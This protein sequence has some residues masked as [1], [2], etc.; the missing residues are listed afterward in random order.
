M[1]RPI[2]KARDRPNIVVVMTDQHAARAIGVVGDPA[3]DTPA[4]DR[5]AARGTRFTNAYCPSPIAY[6]PLPTQ[7]SA[8]LSEKVLTFDRQ[9]FF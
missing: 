5:L 4:L 2:K 3:A 8:A 9:V 7:L 1:S 6:C